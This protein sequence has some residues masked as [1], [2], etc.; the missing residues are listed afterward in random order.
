[1]ITEM[2]VEATLPTMGEMAFTTRLPMSPAPRCFTKSDRA[3]AILFPR[4]EAILQNDLWE[5]HKIE[6][7]IFFWPDLVTRHVRISA[8]LYNSI[9]DYQVLADALLEEL[10][11]EK[12]IDRS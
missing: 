8:Q 5:R 11:R 3:S 4:F 1:M 6:V 9:E 7:P 2:R 10:D 12:R